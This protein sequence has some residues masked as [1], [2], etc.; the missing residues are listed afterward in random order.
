MQKLL[1]ILGVLILVI[2]VGWPWF[3]KLPLGRLP[4]DLIIHK[5]NFRFYLPITS[6]LIISVALSAIVWLLRK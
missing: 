1:F 3:S 5:E 2:G 6:M 4:G